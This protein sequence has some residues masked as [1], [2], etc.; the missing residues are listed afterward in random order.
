MPANKRPLLLIV[1][2][3]IALAA[4]GA[5]Y[6]FGMEEERHTIDGS[7]LLL[8]KANIEES[9]EH[10]QGILDFDD[11]FEGAPVTLRDDRDRVLATGTLAAGS[12]G[13][14]SCTFEFTLSDVPEVSNYR[15]Q[16]NEQETIELARDFFK[17]SQ[18][19]VEVVWGGLD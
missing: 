10:C 9:G 5:I 2:L 13:T 19:K 12:P 18:W 3:A 15:L 6:L 7:V 11:L 17:G 16:I 1:T 8:G 14:S 4:G